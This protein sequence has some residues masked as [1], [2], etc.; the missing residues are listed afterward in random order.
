[1]PIV[2]RANQF[3]E[4][5]LEVQGPVLVDFFGENCMP[6]K[7]LRPILLDLSREFSGLKFCM[8]NADREMFESDEEFEA[9]Y[10]IMSLY[11]VMSLPTLLLFVDG[12]VRASIIGLHTRDELLKFFRDQ[13]VRLTET[14]RAT[15]VDPL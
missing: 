12:A 13:G 4:E 2:V 7:M 10:N 15:P 1:M 6:C 11:Q 9:K 5:V 14:P 8:F 3:V